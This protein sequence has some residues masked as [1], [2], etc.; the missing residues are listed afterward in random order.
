M[1]SLFTAQMIESGACR[2]VYV[3][4]T[5]GVSKSSVI[6]PVNRQR[7]DGSEGFFIQRRGGR[8]GKVLTPEVIEKAQGLL[9]QGYTRSD[10][11]QELNVK[12]DTLRKAINDGRLSESKHK[13]RAISKSSRNVVDAAAGEGMGVACT[14]VEERVLA[15]MGELVGATVRFELCLDVPKGGALCA[16]PALLANGLFH[17]A[18][19]FLGRVT[20]YY[21]IFHVLLLPALMAL[22]RIKTTEKLR[23]HAPGEF[24]KLPGL[25]RIP[26]VRCLRNKMDELSANDGAERRAAH[27]GKYWM[28]LEPEKVTGI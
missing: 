21:T 8:G 27:S 17:G 4:R 28:N 13:E 6:R 7:K 15:S 20:G 3:I 19:E 9:D 2:Q 5:F 11:A 23:G 10:V 24:G 18:E 22:C 26:E 25:D 12:Y 1:F 14:R 16:I